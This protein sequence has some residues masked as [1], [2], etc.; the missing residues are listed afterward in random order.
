MRVA[1]QHCLLTNNHKINVI[2]KSAFHMDSLNGCVLLLFG[3]FSMKNY[4]ETVV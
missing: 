4:A 1:F 3:R 2:N